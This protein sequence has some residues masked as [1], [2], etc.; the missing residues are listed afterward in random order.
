[1]PDISRLETEVRR[2]VH[3]PVMPYTAGIH[4]FTVHS[5]CPYSSDG[6]QGLAKRIQA[7]GRYDQRAFNVAAPQD[8]VLITG[9]DYDRGYVQWLS[10][11]GLGADPENV[12]LL[13]EDGMTPLAQRLLQDKSLRQTL[14]KRVAAHSDMLGEGGTWHPFWY[15]SL[16]REV[17]DRIGVE[18]FGAETKPVR[19]LN[20]KV[21]FKQMC[22]SL[23]IPVV[24]GYTL[25][26]KE[27]EDGARQHRRYASALRKSLRQFG[28]RVFVR[29]NISAAGNSRQINMSDDMA[30]FSETLEWMLHDTEMSAF[31]LERDCSP[32]AS[33]S[34][35]FRILPT[36]EIYRL[37]PVGQQ[38]LL[39][40]AHYGNCYP[41]N[42]SD[43]AEKA[44][45]ELGAQIAIANRNRKFV[46][47]FGIDFIESFGGFLFPVEENPRNTGQSA[48][49]HF[50]ARMLQQE[51]DSS[52]FQDLAFQMGE[53]F[54]LPEDFVQLFY[55]IGEDDKRLHMA[56]VNVET[57]ARS[58]SDMQN[59]LGMLLYQPGRSWGVIPMNIGPL[60]D[61]G[62][63]SLVT[64]G[65]SK[66]D[67]TGVTLLA[68]ARLHL[69]EFEQNV[70]VLRELLL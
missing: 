18:Y 63:F 41:F 68:A 17:A 33:P 5:K 3:N 22:R 67:F 37:S 9:N 66:Q 19:K 27:G 24:E 57:F 30:D 59:L 49:A 25:L 62:K 2:I 16:D 15:S 55:D 58:F 14:E 26:P 8:L 45:V 11:V 7:I 1:M 6:I 54:A 36:G 34:L 44:L 12:V 61:A 69:E 51:T 42:G 31:L 53:L 46:G 47:D 48:L 64:F 4:G 10:D 21:Y 39:Q 32:R 70:A 13:P 29:P 38:I 40:R 43:E 23:G 65:T 35:M 20:D 28:G 60:R 56:S 52:S 50:Y